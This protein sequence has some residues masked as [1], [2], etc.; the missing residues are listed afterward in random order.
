MKN[1][2]TQAA[3]SFS[4]N[5]SD[6]IIERSMNIDPEHSETLGL[7]G[8]N[9][10]KDTV[11]NALA[12]PI[13]QTLAINLIG[14]SVFKKLFGLRELGNIY[15]RAMNP[16]TQVLEERLASNEGGVAALAVAP[17]L[18]AVALANRT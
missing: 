16:S 4:A 9:Y 14:L 5:F 1:R 17:V 10:R 11:T 15:A 8:V 12:I 13:Y 7:H 3:N 18:S 2:V 6:R